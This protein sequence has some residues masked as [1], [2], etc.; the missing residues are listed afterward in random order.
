MK[1]LVICE[2]CGTSF[3]TDSDVEICQSCKGTGSK[4][5]QSVSDTAN[6]ARSK[7]KEFGAKAL[8][9]TKKQK[10][11]AEKIRAEKLN[12]FKDPSIISFRGEWTHSKFWIENR[13]KNGT[14]IEIM[15]NDGV[16]SK[17]KTEA[18]NDKIQKILE[19]S[20]YSGGS[21][22]TEQSSEIADIEAKIAAL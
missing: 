17:A 10:E 13:D 14:Q 21:L 4:K 20:M 2:I 22:T 3:Y 18:L 16:S 7:A 8:K 9:G 5:R 15:V 11:W 12:D 1:D 19:A 6:K